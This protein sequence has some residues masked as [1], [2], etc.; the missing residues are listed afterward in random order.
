MQ[1]A[2]AQTSSITRSRTPTP[3]RTRPLSQAEQAA[4]IEAAR[5]QAVQQGV[6]QAA[7]EA[8]KKTAADLVAKEAAKKAADSAVAAADAESR[9]QKKKEE[10]DKLII[11]LVLAF[12]L[13]PFLGFLYAMLR[14]SK[15]ATVGPESPATSGA[16]PPAADRTH[17]HSSSSAISPSLS[18]TPSTSFAISAAAAAASDKHMSDYRRLIV[19][20]HQVHKGRTPLSFAAA[21]QSATCSI[22]G[23]TGTQFMW[24]L[25]NDCVYHECL[26]CSK[27]LEMQREAVLAN[28][29]K[30]IERHLA[31]GHHL[32]LQNVT[33]S[34]QACTACG[35]EGVRA[36]WRCDQPGCGY[37][38]CLK[39]T[40]LSPPSG[41]RPP[42]TISVVMTGLSTYSKEAYL[43]SFVIPV[44][45][46]W[47]AAVHPETG[48][49]Y[50]FNEA[51]GEA[52]Y[53]RPSELV[54][55]T[56]HKPAAC[57]WLT[58]V[59]PE[60]GETY[61]YNEATGEAVWEKPEGF[62]GAATPGMMAATRHY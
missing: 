40:R 7:E 13:P 21:P 10:N 34:A 8:A 23:E 12:G 22:C 17:V 33:P 55:A 16:E 32:S 24:C 42:R 19:E 54:Q 25:E 3:T 14:P 51:T 27:A 1:Y 30:A 6:S 37:G 59:H 49:T 36:M 57:K 50:Y 58:A 5:N 45:A 39:C 28:V 15:D 60:N 31:E 52:T 56:N 4:I 46:A 44:P 29:K 53:E 43:K 47:V 9:D 35:E 61:Y 41:A 26:P 20:R 38:E 11:G 48:E 2:E 18:A 62:M